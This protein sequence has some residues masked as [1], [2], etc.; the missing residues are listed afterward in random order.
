LAIR[1]GRCVVKARRPTC[2]TRFAAA[3]GRMLGAIVGIE[4]A[5]VQHAGNGEITE[6][7]MGRTK[8]V[9]EIRVSG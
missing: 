5:W 8:G 1:D 6:M 2:D 3:K 4:A 9:E 7:A